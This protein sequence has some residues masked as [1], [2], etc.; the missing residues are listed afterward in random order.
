MSFNKNRFIKE[1]VLIIILLSLIGSVGEAQI[2]G[3]AAAKRIER[4]L[5]GT[6]LKS[7][8]SVKIKQPR[9]VV[10]TQRKQAKSEA[11][12]KKDYAKYIKLSQKRAIEIQ[13]PEVQKRMKQSKK[14][15]VKN[16]RER[17]KA[18]RAATK[19]ASRKYD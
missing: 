9:K 18:V 13:T 12:L 7:K 14:E 2:A 17:R 16:N 6:G 5:T 11:R 3:T 4:S 10:K 15:T 19:K 8:K 1:I